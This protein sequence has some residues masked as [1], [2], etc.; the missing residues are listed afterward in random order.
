MPDVQA[1][2]QF[3]WTTSVKQTF[4][5]RTGNRDDALVSGGSSAAQDDGDRNFSRGLVSVRTDLYTEF[6]AIF[7][8][9]GIRFS[10]AGWY[11]E[12]YQRTNDNDSPGTSQGAGPTGNEFQDATQRLHGNKAELLD[13]FVFATGEVGGFEANAKLGQYALVYG[14]SLFFGNNGIAYGMV[15]LDII[16]ATSL[17]GVQFRDIALPV[18]QISGQITL[19]PSVSLG[20]YY[21]VKWKKTRLPAV[22]SYFSTSDMLDVGGS[23]LQFIPAIPFL[24]P[25]VS[26]DRTADRDP[27][28]SGQGG[29]QLRFS[30]ASIGTDFGLYA[31]RYHERVPTLILDAPAPTGLPPGFPPYLPT[32]YYLYYGKD[33]NA[34]GFSF[35]KAFGNSS[36]AGE[37][38]VRDGAYLAADP[39]PAYA[40][41]GV[42]RGTT[43]HLNLSTLTAFEPN[44]L[45][46]ES[47]ALAELACNRTQKVTNDQP[48]AA[49]STRSACAARVQYEP[50]FRQV[51]S[52]VDLSIPISGS[53]TYGRSSAIPYFGADDSGDINVSFNFSYLDKWRMGLGYTYFYGEPGT[54]LDSSGQAFSYKQSLADRDF[55]SL[56]LAV[57]F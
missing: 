40:G 30:L 41:V 32:Q 11:D 37:V 45:V 50:K 21:Q 33:V 46:K 2:S 57:T 1:V 54:M 20:A 18:R 56:S 5:G 10:G 34:Y 51:M 6:D 48:V 7:D 14:E 23:Q 55:V 16:K 22:G 4:M 27:G 49:N 9:F 24:T 31:I 29:A 25:G 15:P 53:Y 42:P 39:V 13:A 8:G 26:A 38:S 12:I 35:A 36:W 47:T 28:D 17:P 19:T 52:G 43:L 3:N 44:F